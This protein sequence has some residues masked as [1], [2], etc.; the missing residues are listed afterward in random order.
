MKVRRVYKYER[1]L[2]MQL[3]EILTVRPEVSLGITVR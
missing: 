2:L 1:K 3:P